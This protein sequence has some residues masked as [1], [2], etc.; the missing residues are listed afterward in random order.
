MSKYIL[1]VFIFAVIIAAFIKKVPVYD[2]FVKGS[3]E[4]I[5]LILSIFPDRKSVV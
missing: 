2:N 3:K 4:S 1:P 5:S